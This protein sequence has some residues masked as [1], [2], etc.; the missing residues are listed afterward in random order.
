MEVWS[1]LR[2]L[3]KVIASRYPM[4]INR[5]LEFIGRQFEASSM[6]AAIIIRF[7]PLR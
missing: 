5:S 3:L 7:E 4:S 6:A 1:V 2:R